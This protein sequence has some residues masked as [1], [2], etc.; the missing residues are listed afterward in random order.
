M[1]IEWALWSQLRNSFG[2]C[3]ARSTASRPAAWG[4]EVGDPPLCSDS[5]VWAGW[6]HDASVVSVSCL[7]R[8][9]GAPLCLHLKIPGELLRHADTQAPPTWIENTSPRLGPPNAF[10]FK[11]P[12]VFLISEA[13][14]ASGWDAH[15]SIFSDLRWCHDR[16]VHHTDFMLWYFFLLL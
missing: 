15:S 10:F 16:T 9:A 1:L 12:P 4:R 2:Y 13:L 6:S 3:E 8:R 14:R 7:L 11:A 5:W